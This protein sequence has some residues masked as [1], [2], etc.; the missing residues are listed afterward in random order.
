MSWI[1]H[2][3]NQVSHVMEDAS[4]KIFPKPYFMF[5]FKYYTSPCH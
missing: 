5:I 2:V 4:L 1:Y 3:E